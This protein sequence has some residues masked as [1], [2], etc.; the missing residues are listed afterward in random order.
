MKPVNY[1]LSKV[2]RFFSPACPKNKGGCYSLDNSV[3]GLYPC[4]DTRGWLKSGIRCQRFDKMSLSG[5]IMKALMRFGEMNVGGDL[6][7]I[8]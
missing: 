5:R 3:D 8:N 4:E 6:E 2:V 1:Y 7:D